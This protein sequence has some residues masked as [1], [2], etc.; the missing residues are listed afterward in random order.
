MQPLSLISDILHSWPEYWDDTRQNWIPVDPTWESTS[1]I[2]YFNNFDLKH[3]AFVI[4]GKNSTYPLSA[5]SYKSENFSKDVFV[6]FSSLPSEI[7]N[8]I[9]ITY[10]IKNKLNLFTKKLVVNIINNKTSA[11]YNIYPKVNFP[12]HETEVGNIPVI[13]P[14]GTHSFETDLPLGLFAVKAPNTIYV[15]AD[16]AKK[17]IYINK[18]VFATQQLLIFFSILLLILLYIGSKTKRIK[19]ETYITKIKSILKNASKT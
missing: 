1:E 14:L 4:H 8:N 5:G 12:D 17:T 2:D 3:I 19:F 18:T 11:I 15:S 9:N 13:P 7:N 10:E 6:E 16:N